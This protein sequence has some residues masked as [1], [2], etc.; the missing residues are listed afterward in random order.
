MQTVIVWNLQCKFK[1]L[2]LQN[3]FQIFY[4]I[5][6]AESICVKQNVYHAL[7]SSR[8][9]TFQTYFKLWIFLSFQT[10]PTWSNNRICEQLPLSQSFS[11]EMLSVKSNQRGSHWIN[12]RFYLALQIRILNLK[13]KLRKLT[14]C[15]NNLSLIEI[16][17]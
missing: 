13:R 4:C 3:H 5:Q 7:S 12:K 10:D 11:H 15:W 2:A 8:Q 17:S 9:D 1:I 14:V 6:K 16:F